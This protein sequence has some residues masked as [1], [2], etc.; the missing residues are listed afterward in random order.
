MRWEG[1][2]GTLGPFSVQYVHIYC[3]PGGFRNVG[4]ER[5]ASFLDLPAEAPTVVAVIAG[6]HMATGLLCSLP[7]TLLGI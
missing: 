7:P 5:I 2:F 4:P 1:D 6:L 3:S